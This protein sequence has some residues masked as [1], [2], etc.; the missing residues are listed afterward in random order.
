MATLSFHWK[1]FYLTNDVDLCYCH[2][3]FQEEYKNVIERVYQHY[4]QWSKK[5]EWEE[6]TEEV[7]AEVAAGT[8]RLMTNYTPNIHIMLSLSKTV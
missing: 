8:T 7:A 3:H 4:L 1:G 2:S 5:F 6:V